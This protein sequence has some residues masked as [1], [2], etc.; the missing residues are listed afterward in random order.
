MDILPVSI[1]SAN[2]ESF[3]VNQKG[4]IL[5]IIQSNMPDANIPD[6]PIMLVNMIYNPKLNTNIL[7]VREHQHWC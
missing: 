4:T 1:L 6:I 5:L 3:L 2:G 7:L